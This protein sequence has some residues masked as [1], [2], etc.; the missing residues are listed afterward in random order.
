MD[1]CPTDGA[2]GPLDQPDPPGEVP[3]GNPNELRDPNE[4]RDVADTIP[5]GEDS[6]AG[7]WL[8]DSDFVNGTS[9]QQIETS[10]AFQI[11]RQLPGPG[12]PEAFLW[13]GGV[14]IVHLFG[15]A[16]TAAV[17][18]VSR[19]LTAGTNDPRALMHSMQTLMESN[20]VPLMGGE[21]LIFVV[22]AVLAAGFR[23]RPRTSARLG[24]RPIPLRHLVWLVLLL[25]PLSL[26]GGQLYLWAMHGW[27]MMVE[28]VPRLEVFDQLNSNESITRMAAQASFPML[29][30]LVALLPA[31]GE[32]LIFRGVIGRG[33][34]ARWGLVGG[35]LLTSLLF[36]AVHI[37]PAHALALLPLAVCLHVVYLATRSFWAPVTLH[38]LN[39]AWFIVVLKTPGLE[40]QVGTESSAP[41]SWTLFLTSALCALLVAMVIWRS[42]VRYVLPDG[43]FWHPGYNTV[44]SPPVNL[45]A[46][47]RCRRA[48]PTL[49]LAAVLSV[50]AGVVMLLRAIVSGG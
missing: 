15:G 39:N 30:F 24:L 4:P 32:E 2:P 28:I 1:H 19:G 42:R 8:D 17:L 26:T 21:M 10:P 12:L 16:A 22:C 27:Q 3:H 31:V 7:Q 44:E 33:L 45:H 40:S 25:P 34:V 43:T 13:V 37:H 47:A 9:D 5:D 18:I 49:V 6:S 20:L 38:F 36:V 41:I 50:A 23:L 35:A 48:E 46:V 11:E 29:V 14:L